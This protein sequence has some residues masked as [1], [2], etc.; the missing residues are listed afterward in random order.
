MSYEWSYAPTNRA[1]CKVDLGSFQDSKGAHFTSQEGGVSVPLYVIL[2]LIAYSMTNKKGHILVG[3]LKHVLCFTSCWVM[4][5]NDYIPH[6][7]SDGWT[8]NIRWKW[9]AML[10]V[11]GVLF[12]PIP[13]GNHYQDWIHVNISIWLV[14]W[15]I[16]YFP[17]YWE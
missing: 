10:I 6:M 17:I 5:R 4:I 11:F 2:A 16:F 13:M 9:L 1:K 8:P 7:F 12:I 14:V 3:G 15:N